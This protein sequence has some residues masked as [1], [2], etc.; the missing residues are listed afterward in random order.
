MAGENFDLT[1]TQNFVKYEGINEKKLKAL[2]LTKQDYSGSGFCRFGAN[3]LCTSADKSLR[4]KLLKIRSGIH[5]KFT[6]I[7]LNHAAD[8]DFWVG[9]YLSGIVL[10]NFGSNINITDR[11]LKAICD[12]MFGCQNKSQ[13][14]YKRVYEKT[15]TKLGDE[16]NSIHSE[17]LKT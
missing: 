3:V 12:L 9:V 5:S 13:G 11:N 17:K 8:V 6:T 7:N 2:N 15:A 16:K 14:A 4:K 10:N 1:G